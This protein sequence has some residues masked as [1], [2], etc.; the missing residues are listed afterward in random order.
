MEKF[1]STIL[2][3]IIG[4]IFYS[5]AVLGFAVFGIIAM[6]NNYPWINEKMI[7][8]DIGASAGIELVMVYYVAKYAGSITNEEKLR[9]LYI[10][11][12][13]ERKEYIS[14]KI[15]VN[16]LVIIMLSL[17]LGGIIAGYFNMTV[18]VTLI[19]AAIFCALMTLGLK[20]YYNKKY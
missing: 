15:G 18:F 9:K 7:S 6:N 12:T 19:A 8:F 4:F 10:E 5:V 17:L 20:I 13:D 1:K 16:G 3:R 2:K 11:E 14:S